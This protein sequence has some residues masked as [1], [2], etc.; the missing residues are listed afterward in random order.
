MLALVT[1][2]GMARIRAG[3]S[4]FVER[5]IC[6][7]EV[8][9]YHFG[10][11]YNKSTLI[12]CLKRL[13]LTPGNRRVCEVLFF[14]PSTTTTVARFVTFGGSLPASRCRSLSSALRSD[15][16]HQRFA[17][18][19][20]HVSFSTI[21]SASTEAIPTPDQ[22]QHERAA[23]SRPLLPAP[24]F[25][26]RPALVRLR[27]KSV[28]AANYKSLPSPAFFHSAGGLTSLTTAPFDGLRTRI[29]SFSTAPSS[30]GR[31]I[32]LSSAAGPAA[33]RGVSFTGPPSPLTPVF[34]LA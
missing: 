31:S 27:A 32:W 8:D 28:A 16:F 18:R 30:D 11:G 14:T 12:R 20:G 23:A 7:L 25:L 2:E 3:D 19:G 33:S 1:R 5:A 15:S 13:S 22:A 4:E 10:S 21:L 17:C 6:Y 9:P 24:P 26:P 29:D 34:R